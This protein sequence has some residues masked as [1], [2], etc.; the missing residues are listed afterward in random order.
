MA[1]WNRKGILHGADYYPEQWLDV[2]EILEQDIRMMK[3][4]HINTVT[5][6]VF[7]WAAL[8]P[9]EGLWK[10]EWLDTVIDRLWQN[11][12]GVILATP[13]G[14]RPAWLAEK[15]PEVLRMGEDRHRNLYGMRMNHCYTS[16][17]YRRLTSRIDRML[18]QRYGC[19]PAVK[20]WH[21]SNEY[22]GECHCPLCQAAFR[23]FLKSKYGTLE[24]LNHAWWTTFWSKTYTS[25]EQIVSPSFRGEKALQGLELDWKRFVTHQT[26][27]FL[28]L[29]IGAVRRFSPNVPITTNMI[30]SFIEVDYPRLGPSLD[31]AG[32][33]IYPEWGSAPDREVAVNAAFEY[34]VARSLKRLPFL[35][36]ET[37]P[38]MT[39]WTEVGKPKRP[40][41]HLAGCL[42]AVAHGAESVIYFQ[43]RKSRGGYEKF[44]GAVVG[45]SGH[46]KTR[47]FHEVA[48]LGGLL[49]EIGEITGSECA[50]KAALLYDWNNRWAIEGAKG[51]RQD[52]KYEST[53]R[54]H[55]AALRRYGITVD[56]VDEEQPLNG[57]ELVAAPMLYLVKDGLKE[58]LET[59]VKAG[60]ILLLTY[61]SGIV[62]AS[63]L[64]FTGG[65][66]GPLRALA[67]VWAEELDTLYPK[68]T[69]GI[70]M[71]PDND[72]GLN[73]SWSCNYFC[74]VIHTETAE[75][76]AVY[77]GDW[78]ADTPALTLNRF[79]M[80]ETW[81]L[82]A[83]AEPEFL[84]KLYGRLLFRKKP[85]T[86]DR[87]LLPDGVD[88]SV[89]QKGNCR[90]WFFINFSDTEQ[91]LNVPPGY[92]MIGRR[93]VGH[94]MTLKP[95]EAAVIKCAVNGIPA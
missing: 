12:I 79:G 40:G 86:C 50:A 60:G 83:H 61:F 31:I 34:D 85:L 28:D 52:K 7:A 32:L 72:L 17:A 88:L 19:H 59:F 71:L 55:Y 15:Y 48:C 91:E 90:Y 6:G 35:L 37:T 42:Q 66:P 94:T 5:L 74:E 62:D 26:K 64:C 82:A 38:S 18:A 73:G 43:W 81:Y 1:V 41:M 9:E 51:P 75:C 70:R 30:G 21:I 27:E 44:H 95:L 68:E 92:D 87:A 36:M 2:P 8:E 65:F 16:P 49:E 39:N 67:G 11:G 10:F 53:V 93:Q 84:V 80:G 13:S 69:N 89:R 3:L 22:H 57:Y 45:H 54:E 47:I 77:D 78:Y 20:A 46:E 56:L 29:E 14:A 63:D 25:W 58:K 33:D 24:R 4:A 76:C 23:N